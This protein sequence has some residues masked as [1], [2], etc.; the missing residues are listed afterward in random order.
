[1]T[2]L[3]FAIKQI[4][5]QYMQIIKIQKQQTFS[6]Y[7]SASKNPKMIQRKKENLHFYINKITLKYK[8]KY[9]NKGFRLIGETIIKLKIKIQNKISTSSLINFQLSSKNIQISKRIKVKISFRHFLASLNLISLTI[10]AITA[11]ANHKI[12]IKFYKRVHKYE[13]KNKKIEM[14]F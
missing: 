8:K 13:N 7:Q 2:L 12:K 5:L 14:N 11:I 10:K 4:F 3:H 1:M 6:I 9:L